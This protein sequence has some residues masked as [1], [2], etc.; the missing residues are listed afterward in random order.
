MKLPDGLIRSR[1]LAVIVAVGTI[2]S[3]AW[4][5]PRDFRIGN[6]V[7]DAHYA[8]LAK[9]IRL[10]GRYRTLNL[11]GQPPETKFPPAFPALLAT[12][13]SLQRSDPENLERLR[14]VNLWLVGAVA[15][16]LVLVGS[17]VLG[18]NPWVAAVFAV[19]G[20]LSPRTVELW[21]VPLSGPMLLLLLCLGTVLLAGGRSGWAVVCMV[22]AVYVRTV[23]LPFLIGILAVEWFRSR[24][25]RPPWGML[26]GAAA[27]LVPW[28]RWQ[29][30]YAGVVPRAALGMHGS[31]GR[32]YVDS[33]GADPGLVLG[34]V[35]ITNLVL[36]LRELGEGLLAVRSGPELLATALGGL[37]VFAAWR[38]RDRA[39][40]LMVGLIG[41]G[42][43]VMLWPFPPARFVAALWPLVLIVAGSALSARWPAPLAA[44]VALALTVPGVR[45]NQGVLTHRIRTRLSDATIARLRGRIPVDAVL[46]STNPPLHYLYFGVPTVPV[47]R[48]RTYE[49]YRHHSWDDAWGDGRDLVASIRTF[50]VTLVVTEGRG[51]EGSAVADVRAA[52]PGFLEPAAA[53]LGDTGPFRVDRRVPCDL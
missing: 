42:L 30:L 12:G 5:L 21:T 1:P 28:L 50:D 22:F 45:T 3:V 10:G 25:L 2:W 46:A 13:W 38:V 24:R 43:I 17:G 8:M 31:Y 15:G 51:G 37:V 16:A 14:S 26:I 40:A 41:Y 9:A 11:P 7:D 23:A 48:M 52:C 47:Q 44:L 19:A 49:W 20:L 35:P 39:P 34:R 32:W 53:E 36:S 6:Y 4:S 33:V 27:G 29:L 18:V